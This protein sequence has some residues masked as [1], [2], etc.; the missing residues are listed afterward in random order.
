MCMSST[1][2]VLGAS[3]PGVSH[4]AS[5]TECQD[6]HAA[7]QLDD[8]TLILAVA[9]GAGSAARAADGATCAVD[10]AVEL[11]RTRLLEDGYPSSDAAWQQFLRTLLEDTRIALGQLAG[12]NVLE[13]HD[14]TALEPYATTLLL[15]VVTPACVAAA[16]VGDGAIVARLPG[17]TYETLTV[18]V[19]G[20]YVNE[21][22]FL[23]EAEYQLDSQYVVR[24]VDT[25][26]GLLLFTDGMER[27][28]LQMPGAAPF[29]PSLKPV[30][31]F[32]DASDASGE[33]LEQFLYSPRVCERTTDDKTMLF[34]VRA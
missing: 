6:N 20:R 22:A 10:T 1:W 13:D 27:L 23:T 32:A 15:A 2:R 5:G 8:G 28:L 29:V 21:T 17:D 12:V 11:A 26:T 18:P 34:A 14:A 16:Q 25:I 19:H 24:P 33:D 7:I 31:T 3:V 4:L 30:F 9:D